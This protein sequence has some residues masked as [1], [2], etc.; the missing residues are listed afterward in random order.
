MKEK[1]KKPKKNEEHFQDYDRGLIG[2]LKGDKGE[3]QEGAY[4]TLKRVKKEDEGWDPLNPSKGHIDYLK[5]V[6]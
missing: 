2:Q 4:R 3:I 5:H 6:R 1:H